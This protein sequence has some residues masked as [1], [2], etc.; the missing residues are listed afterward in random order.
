MDLRRKKLLSDEKILRKK[1]IEGEFQRE[2][3]RKHDYGFT[4]GNGKTGIR[5]GLAEVVY[6]WNIPY[7]K[8]CPGASELCRQVCYNAAYPRNKNSDENLLAYRYE[9]KKL[10]SCLNKVL[11]RHTNQERVIVRLHSEGDFF[12]KEY[13]RFWG[14]IIKANPKVHFWTYTRSWRVE[15]LREE[16][17]YL[18]NL[19]NINLYFSWDE[20]MS[21]RTEHKKAILTGNIEAYI[22]TV[23]KEKVVC[24]EQLCLVNGCV[25]CGI[26]LFNKSSD[27]VFL[28]H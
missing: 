6:T 1:I 22:K 2:L 21:E 10:M 15:E 17:E 5:G 13:I 8:T 3:K 25:N 24:P 26:C 11:A 19:D 12:S 7:V 18:D 16:L 14:E 28:I 9:R 27:V 20:T 23:D 4:Q